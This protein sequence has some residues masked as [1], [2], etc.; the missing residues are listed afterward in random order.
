MEQF[1]QSALSLS[2]DDIV[3]H[4]KLTRQ[5]LLKECEKLKNYYNSPKSNVNSN[6]FVG[7]KI[8]YHYQLGNLLKCK[9]EGGISFYDLWT[10]PEYQ[11]QKLKHIQDTFKRGRTGSVANRLFEAWRINKGCI[12]FFKASQAI[13]LIKTRNSRFVADP[14]AGWGGRMLGAWAC[15][16]NYIGC[17]TNINLKGGYDEM[18]KLLNEYDHNSTHNG[19]RGLGVTAPSLT[20]I[21]KSC[22]N[23][24]WSKYQYDCVLTSP[25][26]VNMELY[27]CMQPFENDRSFYQDFMTPIFELLKNNMVN[28]VI[29]W[30]ISPKMYIDWLKYSGNEY[31]T[32]NQIDLKQQLGQNNKKRRVK[33]MIY[34]Y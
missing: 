33:D 14:T 28:G 22:L 1:I 12:A 3:S 9:R 34:V 31:E 7:N 29:Y 20:M 6:S 30:N 32:N 8:I 13:Y 5:Q 11:T 2:F 21:W 15:G 27:E 19:V 10:N 26:Y 24:D 4:K 23:V 18:I 25:P 16:S 17:D